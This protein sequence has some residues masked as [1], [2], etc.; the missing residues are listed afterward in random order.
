M[1]KILEALLTDFFNDA[2]PFADIVFQKLIDIVFFVENHISDGSIFENTLLQ[3]NR[4][5]LFFDTLFKITTGFGIALLMFKFLKKMFDTYILG[6]DGDPSNS[7]ENIIIGFMK[8]LT[9]IFCF[10]WLY[11]V[12]VNISTEFIDKILGGVGFVIKPSL[13]EIFKQVFLGSGIFMLLGLLV[14]FI[15]YLILVFQ[16]IRR[17]LE[18]FIL[19]LGVPLAC[20]GLIDSDKGVFAP[21]IKLFIQNSLTVVIQLAMIKLGF[22]IIANG[23]I[24]F[25][26]GTM[27]MGIKTPQ[28][29]QQ[30]MI[31]VGGN[32]INIMTINQTAS[33]ISRIS[34]TT[35]K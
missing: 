28:F 31:A 10:T 18:M 25:G 33:M 16:F 22:G 4:S 8:A 5:E 29:L 7:V 1:T 32:G 21:Y 2:F 9:I 20:V 13:M 12:F 23:N 24:F 26:I 19:R 35:K 11:E 15:C 27:I 3:G 30:F 17:G 34:K 6:L 14:F